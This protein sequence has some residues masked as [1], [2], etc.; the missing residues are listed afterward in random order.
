VT[1]SQACECGAYVTKL[2]LEAALTDPPNT[3]PVSDSAV[4]HQLK[5]SISG[6]TLCFTATISELHAGANLMVPETLT[7]VIDTVIKGTQAPARFSVLNDI[8]GGVSCMES[9]KYLVGKKILIIL[10]R[11]ETPATL[12][13][14]GV[15]LNFCNGVTS[16][17][18]VTKSRLVK[19][20]FA[21]STVSNIWYGFAESVSWLKMFGRASM[22]TRPVRYQGNVPAGMGQ[23]GFGAFLLNGRSVGARANAP[24]AAAHVEIIQKGK[25]M[26]RMEK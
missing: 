20:G 24:R 14:M 10:S 4:M 21:G 9:A 25:K 23:S 22:S 13:A 18:F 5:D 16:G 3:V 19:V 1:A 26:L 11:D 8:M 12:A 7:M 6:A 2:D 17:I 15:S